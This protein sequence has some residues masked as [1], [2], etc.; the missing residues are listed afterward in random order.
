MRLDSRSGLRGLLMNRDTGERIRFV[1]W[2]EIPDDPEQPGEFEA[3]RCEPE[4]YKALGLPLTDIIYRGKARLRF[5]PAAPRIPGKPTSERDLAGS[6][7]EARAR[8]QCKPLLIDPNNPRECDEPKCH[9]LALWI[10]SDEQEIEPQA[11]GKGA[12]GERAVMLGGRFYCNYHYRQPTF[13]SVRGV[14]NEVPIEE[15]RPQ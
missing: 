15:A 12:L 3:F 5:I 11:D 2:A 14:T 9:R 7:D 1:R 10:V 6:L 13:T 8:L 4:A